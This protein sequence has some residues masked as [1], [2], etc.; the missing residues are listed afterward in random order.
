MRANFKRYVDQ[1]TQNVITLLNIWKIE[2]IGS[3]LSVIE[4]RKIASRCRI[5]SSVSGPLRSLL[6]A[7]GR[8]NMTILYGFKEIQRTHWDVYGIY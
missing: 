2:T 3:K 8:A 4:N 5:A 6:F 1:I 7:R